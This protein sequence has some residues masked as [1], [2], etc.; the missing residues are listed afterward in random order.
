MHAKPSIIHFFYLSS[1]FYSPSNLV[2][3]GFFS[4]HLSHPPLCSTTLILHICLPLILKKK[5]MFLFFFLQ[6]H[7]D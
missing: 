1:S 2:F 6:F 3:L 5:T 4:C 7:H